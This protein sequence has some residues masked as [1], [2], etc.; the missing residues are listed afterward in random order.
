MEVAHP[1]TSSFA[2][3]DIKRGRQDLAR[4]CGRGFRTPV[5]IKGFIQ[6]GD[7]GIGPDDGTSRE[8]S[9]TVEELQMGDPV[10]A[11]G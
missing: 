5:I 11:P 1:N 10:P 6:D 4:R 7:T 8:F 3:L 2:L 9:V